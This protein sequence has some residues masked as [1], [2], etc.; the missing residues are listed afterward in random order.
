LGGGAQMLLQSF[1]WAFDAFVVG[2]NEERIKR[3]MQEKKVEKEVA[4]KI[5]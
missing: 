4:E 3:I 1:G 5:F 2:F